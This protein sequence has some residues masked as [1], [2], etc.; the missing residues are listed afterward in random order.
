MYS[1]LELLL[2]FS[3]IDFLDTFALQYLD[4]NYNDTNFFTACRETARIN[5]CETTLNGFQNHNLLMIF[6]FVPVTVILFPRQ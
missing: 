5:Q 6:R 2:G 1:R 4:R 3:G